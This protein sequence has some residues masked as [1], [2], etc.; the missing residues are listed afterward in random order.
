MLYTETSR[1]CV[2]VL[3]FASRCNDTQQSNILVDESG[4]ARIADFGLAAMTRGV[5]SE[6]STS[7]DEGHGA[8]WTAPEVL[9]DQGVYSKEADVFSF[10]MVMIQVCRKLSAA[11]GTFHLSSFYPNAGIHWCGSI[12]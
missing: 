10:A 2:T 4:H 11:C 3:T 8:R 5:N 7:G 6:L 12:S 1:E 9:T